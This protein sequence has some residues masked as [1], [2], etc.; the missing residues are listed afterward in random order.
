M[1][2]KYDVLYRNISSHHA[3][4]EACKYVR[5]NLH[6]NPL[7]SRSDV[8]RTAREFRQHTALVNK[9]ARAI[10]NRVD[11]FEI[12]FVDVKHKCSRRRNHVNPPLMNKFSREACETSEC[13][14]IR[15]R[16]KEVIKYA[17]R[18]GKSFMRKSVVTQRTIM[19]LF[20]QRPLTLTAVFN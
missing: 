7:V 20:R 19:V 4:K 1:N 8:L 16:G 6:I 2:V 11:R 3:C 10:A 13:A 17:W 9:F 18:I 12:H 5:A 15:E 14:F